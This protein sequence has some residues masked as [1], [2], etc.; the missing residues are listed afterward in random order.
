MAKKPEPAPE[1]DTVTAQ[2]IDA[3]DHDRT[4]YGPGDTVDLPRPEALKLR[5]LGVVTFDAAATAPEVPAEEDGA[6]D[7][8]PPAE[9]T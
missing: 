8:V 2:V 9:A 7:P 1:P 5:G 4:V 6:T 3:L